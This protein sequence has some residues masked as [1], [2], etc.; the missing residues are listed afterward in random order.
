[1]MN[2]EDLILHQHGDTY[3][4]MTERRDADAADLDPERRWIKGARTF[5][6]SCGHTFVLAPSNPGDLEN[7]RPADRP[8]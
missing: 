5:D 1:M 3:E 8:A 2:F 7:A 4:H 6:C